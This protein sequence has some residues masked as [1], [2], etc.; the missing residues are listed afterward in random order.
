MGASGSRRARASNAAAT[1]RT[2]LPTGARGARGLKGL[3]EA[4]LAHAEMEGAEVGGQV[5]L[6]AAQVL[7]VK[8]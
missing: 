6:G 7:S 3:L 5:G 2:G 8:T 1:P 4:G